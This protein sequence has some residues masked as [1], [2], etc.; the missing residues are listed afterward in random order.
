MI[1]KMIT[2]AMTMPA[3]A[4][5]LNTTLLAT[6]VSSAMGKVVTVGVMELSNKGELTGGCKIT[7]GCELTGACELTD[8]CELTG[9]RVTG[10]RLGAKFKSGEVGAFTSILYKLEYCTDPRPI[11]YKCL[12]K[13]QT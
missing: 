6:T 13:V 11:D 8:G 4:P 12:N 7:C 2:T 10:L 1:P 5:A 9:G 3:I